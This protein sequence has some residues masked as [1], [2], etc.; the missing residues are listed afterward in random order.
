MTKH[1]GIVIR[2]VGGKSRK[3]GA[4]GVFFY[5]GMNFQSMDF[6]VGKFWSKFFILA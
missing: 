2:L 3:D 6:L 5:F 4:L 1:I